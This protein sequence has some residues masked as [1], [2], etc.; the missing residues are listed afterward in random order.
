MI[1]LLPPL[2][3]PRQ[4]RKAQ[5][6]HSGLRAEYEKAPW[7][8]LADGYYTVKCSCGWVDPK[9][10][11]VYGSEVGPLVHD[12]GINLAMNRHLERA[13]GVRA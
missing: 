5:K 11:E 10:I 3:T 13:Y 8:R 9:R 1:G 2:L 7:W 6:E 4:L 12:L